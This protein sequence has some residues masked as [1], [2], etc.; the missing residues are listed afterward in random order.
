MVIGSNRWRKKNKPDT[1]NWK[2]YV[3]D[4]VEMNI[5]QIDLYSIKDWLLGDKY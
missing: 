4:D 5:P 3:L 2:K 1:E